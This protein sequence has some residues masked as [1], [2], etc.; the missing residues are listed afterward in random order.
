MSKFVA[1]FWKAAVVPDVY[2]KGFS[3]EPEQIDLIIEG[4]PLDPSTINFILLCGFPGSGKSTFAEYLYR[5]HNFEILSQDVIGCRTSFDAALSAACKKHGSKLV[6]DKCSVSREKRK[7]ILNTAGGPVKVLCIF[8]DYSADVC[9]NRA[10]KRL[11]H[12]VI[13]QGCGA[14]AVK[15][16]VNEFEIPQ[17]KEGFSTI[18]TIKSIAAADQLMMRF[19]GYVTFYKFPR[20]RHLANLGSA[21]RDDLLY[22]SS[23]VDAFLKPSPNISITIQEK[24]DGANMGISID[25]ETLA[26]RVQNR[27]HFVN[28]KSHLQFKKLD[29][30]IDRNKEDLLRVLTCDNLHAP[31]RY[32][33]FGE[34]LAAKHSVEYTNLP[35]LFIAFDIFDS[36]EKKFFSSKRLFEAL[37]MTMIKTVPLVKVQFRNTQDAISEIEKGNISAFGDSRLE[38][39]YF[40]REDDDWL[41]DRAK[42]VRSDFIE[43]KDEHWAKKAI[44]WNQVSSVFQE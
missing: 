34:W 22:T 17:L 24:V 40:R 1:D 7:E 6:V 35:D 32:I 31:G 3:T 39:Y 33:L 29:A 36:I 11:G 41:I 9:I 10:N 37:R 20:T 42:I 43:D 27:S 2:S 19:G 14:S 30:W 13:R 23:E 44:T 28:S 4:A 21:T 12:P 15:N 8:F 16:F 18:A 25:R 26:L 5:F 38:G